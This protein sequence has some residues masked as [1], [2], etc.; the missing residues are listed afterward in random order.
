MFGFAL[1]FIVAQVVAIGDLLSAVI[2][3]PQLLGLLLGAAT[4]LAVE[5]VKQPGLRPAVQRALA[6]G[7]SGVIGLLTVL[8]AGDADPADVISTI[9]LTI[10][11][12]Q[13]AYAD[14]W[15]PAG[16][17]AAIASRTAIVRRE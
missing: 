6:I 12:S 5:V 10:T 8:T 11:A 17:T 13:A 15:K 7:L 9:I 14:L 2:E 16:V 1:L 3:H 4:P